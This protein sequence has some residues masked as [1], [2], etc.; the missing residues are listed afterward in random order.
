M[1]ETST[2]AIPLQP[3]Y[4]DDE[5][6]EFADAPD[7]ES[8]ADAI[9]HA[10]IESSKKD[11][12][13]KKRQKSR[14]KRLPKPLLSEEQILKWADAYFAEHGQFPAL[15]SRWICKDAIE[16]WQGINSALRQWLRGLPGGSSL[17][18][19][20]SAN[21]NVGRVG[22]PKTITLARLLRDRRA[23]GL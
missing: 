2:N 4:F 19:L 9:H 17:L 12:P 5:I 21:R 8:L 18:K 6:I 11:R 1:A 16:T 22:L 20:L 14:P 15:S 10:V 3:S 23:A 13:T 7:A